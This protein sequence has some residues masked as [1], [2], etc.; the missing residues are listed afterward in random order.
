MF[1]ATTLWFEPWTAHEDGSWH[2]D[3][4]FLKPDEDDQRSVV[5]TRTFFTRFI[6][7]YSDDLRHR[8]AVALQFRH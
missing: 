8:S 7:V 5:A 2:R 1:R 6:D 4:Q 3:V